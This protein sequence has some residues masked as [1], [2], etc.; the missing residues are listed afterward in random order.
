MNTHLKQF[1]FRGLLFGGF[2]PIVMSIVHAV[3]EHTVPAFSLSGTQVLLAVVS[4]YLLAF[5]Q[6]G[7]SVFNQIEHWSLPK[8]LFCH[9]GLLYIAYVLCYLANT[10]IP[11]EPTVLLVFTGIFVVVYVVVWLTVFFSV[12][13]ASK[14]LNASLR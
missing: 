8:S 4:T 11:F 1:L 13:A 3:L 6:A 2:G 9:F 5:V 10:W 12:K 7:A 14:R